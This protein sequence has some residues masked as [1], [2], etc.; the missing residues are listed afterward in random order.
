MSFTAGCIPAWRGDGNDFGIFPGHAILL[1]ST[2]NGSCF[3]CENGQPLRIADET[4]KCRQLAMV[5]LF[6]VGRPLIQ[7]G[8]RCKK[9][10]TIMYSFLTKHLFHKNL[11]LLENV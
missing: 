6:C 4:V 7:I 5:V 2:F 9:A 3:V 10:I 11:L 8:G 1:L